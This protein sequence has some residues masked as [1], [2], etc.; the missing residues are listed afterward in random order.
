MQ[1]FI[2][3]YKRKQR[4]KSSTVKLQSWVRMIKSHRKFL[5][6]RKRRTE[7]KRKIFHVMYVKVRVDYLSRH[8]RLKK[9]FRAIRREADDSNK[10]K[11]LLEKMSRMDMRDGATSAMVQLAVGDYAGSS[12]T[13]SVL[14]GEDNYRRAQ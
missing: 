5:R 2:H 7:R 9:C 4:S 12:H 11:M 14:G 1:S 6:W 10:V 8:H 3:E 13:Q